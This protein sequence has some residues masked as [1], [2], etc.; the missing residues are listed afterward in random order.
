MAQDKKTGKGMKMAGMDM[1]GADH[2]HH[3]ILG[4]DATRVEGDLGKPA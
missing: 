3:A 2:H 1:A 4:V